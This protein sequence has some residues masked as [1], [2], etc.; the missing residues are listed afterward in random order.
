[1]AKVQSYAANPKF[2]L[3]W[4]PKVQSYV[5]IQSPILCG[6]PKSDHTR[7]PKVR[8]YAAIRPSSFVLV[9]THK[10][11]YQSSF[12]HV[13]T[14]A[15][16]LCLVLIPATICPTLTPA[17]FIFPVLFGS[18]TGSGNVSFVRLLR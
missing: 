9:L 1:V 10:A 2:D 17:A 18:Y 5:A 8:S 3:T 13:L 6:D 15:F 11:I 4:Q 16:H 12:V 7:Q 14:P